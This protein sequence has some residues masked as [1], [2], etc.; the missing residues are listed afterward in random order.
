MKI[1]FLWFGKSKYKDYDDLIN[2]FDKRLKH[3]CKHRILTLKDPKHSG[4]PHVQK[5][6]EGQ[7]IMEQLKPSDYLI[8]LD[9][10]GQSITSRGLST[11]LQ[12]QMNAST[13]H[14]FFLIGGAYGVDQPI[15]DRSNYTL[16][17]SKMTLT[18]DMARLLIMEQVYRA[19]TILNG[20]KYHND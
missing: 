20:E 14:I 1:T 3:Y 6:K 7:L 16:S 4:N 17:L 11:L 13:A 12:K 10:T 9:E 5:K 19:F 2:L 15:F 8:L 18:H